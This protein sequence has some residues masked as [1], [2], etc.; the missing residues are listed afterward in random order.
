MTDAEASIDY[1]IEEIENM[2]DEKKTIPKK[3]K[4]QLETQLEDTKKNMDLLM[5]VIFVLIGYC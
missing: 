2:V 3:I 4:E 1:Y 5:E